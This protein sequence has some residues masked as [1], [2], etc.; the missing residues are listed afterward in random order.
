MASWQLAAPYFTLYQDASSQPAA[1]TVPYDTILG[2]V[3]YQAGTT[4]AWTSIASPVVA[5]DEGWWLST[6]KFASNASYVHG[7]APQNPRGWTETTTFSAATAAFLGGFPGAACSLNNTIIY[8]AAGYTVGTDSPSIRIFNGTFDREVTKLPN[9]T[10]GV[11][12]KAIMTM[13]AANG[14]VYLTTFDSGTTS[15]DWSGRAFKLDVVSGTLTPLGVAFTAGHMPYALCWHMGRL[16]CGTH[17]QV[18]TAVGKVYFIRPSIDTTWT[19]DYDLGSA[20][21]TG[22]TSLYSYKGLLY[23]GCTAAAGTFSKVLVRSTVGVYT[24]SDTGTGGTARTNNGFLS[25]TTFGDNLYAGYFNPDTTAIAKI[26]KFDNSSWTTAYTGA[27][28]TLKPFVALPTD[29]TT[30]L[31]VGGGKGYASCLLTSTDGTSWTDQT[32]NALSGYS[33]TPAFAVIVP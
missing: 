20:T 18:S 12:P 31:A 13:L 17:R 28:T 8:A 29:D 7:S 23:V 6:D 25:M 15:A 24:T 4:I 26:R 2:G 27:T 32:T 5:S 9:T 30:L 19:E 16:W 1:Y 3:F 14:T 10:A 11:V 33:G 22:V 21:Q